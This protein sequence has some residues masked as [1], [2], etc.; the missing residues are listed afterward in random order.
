M[1]ILLC[2]S[3]QV[4]QARG[5]LAGARQHAR[6]LGHQ[7]LAAG[8]AGPTA[9]PTGY[10]PGSDCSLRPGLYPVGRAVRGQCL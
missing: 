8:A 1:G 3:G 10:A 7:R 4:H 2:L 5:G 6:G 9:R